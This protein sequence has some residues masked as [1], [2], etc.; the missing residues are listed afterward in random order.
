MS[1]FT[2]ACP[3]GTKMW[4]PWQKLLSC[5]MYSL[6]FQPSAAT[7]MPITARPPA[8][9]YMVRGLRDPSHAA[10]A[11]RRRHASTNRVTATSAASTMPSCITQGGRWKIHWTR[12]TS[13]SGTAGSTTTESR[14]ADDAGIGRVSAP[15]VCMCTPGA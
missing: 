14:S 6:A 7:P 10:M 13:G 12:G 8:S 9:A 4:H 3:L 1:G 11:A 5:I 2:Q 15:G